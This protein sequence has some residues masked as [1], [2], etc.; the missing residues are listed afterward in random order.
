MTPKVVKQLVRRIDIRRKRE[1]KG[2]DRREVKKRRGKVLGES[3]EEAVV[4]E[5][6][7]GG[8]EEEKRRG[9]EMR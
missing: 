4:V 3:V 2:A 8:E 7:Q 1:W 9:L 5:R 6:V